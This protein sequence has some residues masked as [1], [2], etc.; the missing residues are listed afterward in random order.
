MKAK[1]RREDPWAD[2][3]DMS[4]GLDFVHVKISCDVHLQFLLCRE[5]D[6]ISGET[7]K[8]KS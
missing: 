4:A 1:R 6:I 5:I 3:A 2:R 7:T 8:L